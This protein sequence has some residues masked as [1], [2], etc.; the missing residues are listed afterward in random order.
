MHD[1]TQRVSHALRNR[2]II[3][4]TQRPFLISFSFCCLSRAGYCA[5]YCGGKESCGRDDILRHRTTPTFQWSLLFQRERPPSLG[6]RSIDRGRKPRHATCILKD[7][8]AKEDNL[9]ARIS[10]QTFPAILKRSVF[11]ASLRRTDGPA[12]DSLCGVFLV[13]MPIFAQAMESLAKGSLDL[14]REGPWV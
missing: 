12:P 7:Y 8:S 13:S 10:R 1:L 3:K 9:T 2:P 6:I 11:E 14:F 4:G 5:G